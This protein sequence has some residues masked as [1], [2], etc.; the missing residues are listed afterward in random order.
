MKNFNLQ[1]FIYG[2][3]FISFGLFIGILYF[4]PLAEQEKTFLN[5]L[6]IVPTVVTIDL[7]IVLLFS[8]YLWKLWIF[9]SWLVMIP[10]LNGTWKGTIKSNWINPKIN[11]KP[12]PIPVILTIK[13]TLFHISCVMRTQEMASYSF[14]SGFMVDEES[15]MKRLAYSYNSKPS[16]DVRQRSPEHFGTIFFDIVEKPDLRM[17]G[18]YWTERNTTG[19]IEMTYWKS[20]KLDYYPDD[21]GEHPVSKN[22]GL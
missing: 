5:Y 1:Y 16:L 4:F 21:L 18:E 19:I 7:F 6:K 22:E 20:E 14:T 9:K 11:E 3:I 8:K 12:A 17:K 15:Q 2:L 13:Q 10:N